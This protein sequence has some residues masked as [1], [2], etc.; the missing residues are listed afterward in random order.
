MITA[1]DAERAA[2]EAER[3]TVEAAEEAKHQAI[4][5]QRRADRRAKKRKAASRGFRGRTAA[6]CRARQSASPLCQALVL[7]GQV[8]K[9][10]FEFRIAS[11]QRHNIP[12]SR[13]LLM[14][15]SSFLIRT[16]NS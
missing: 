11:T 10:L 15:M 1:R 8:D 5:E 13:G 12:K 16:E 7:T 14:I 6:S 4:L 3:G 2:R 9:L